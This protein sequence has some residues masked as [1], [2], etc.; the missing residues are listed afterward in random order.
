V[1]SFR[2]VDVAGRVGTVANDNGF[3]IAK[4][5]TTTGD[6][7]TETEGGKRFTSENS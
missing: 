7:C 1:D 5:V 4:D 3:Y 2:G 6:I